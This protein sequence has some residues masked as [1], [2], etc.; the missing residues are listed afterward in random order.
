MSTFTSYEY[1]VGYPESFKMSE[2]AQRNAHTQQQEYMVK[3]C[4][5]L[6]VN[7]TRHKGYRIFVDNM[8]CSGDL[9]K[10][11]TE[12]LKE[13]VPGLTFRYD[14]RTWVFN[15]PI[16]FLYEEMSTLPG[17]QTPDVVADISFQP[18]PYPEG[19]PE[20][21]KMSEEDQREAHKRDVDR[22]TRDC[23]NLVVDATKNKQY[24]IDVNNCSGVGNPADLDTEALKTMVPGIWFRYNKYPNTYTLSWP[25]TFLV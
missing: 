24:R 3:T 6:I 25:I 21:H 9:S 22:T 12:A 14:G 18:S 10:L 23:Y 11:N 1:P 8:S 5:D 2:E 17:V 20:T 16:T 15:W 19:Y 13:M 4:Y 7:S